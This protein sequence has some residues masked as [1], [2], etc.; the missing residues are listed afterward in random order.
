LLLPA[1]QKVREAAARA[2]C[3]NNLKQMSLAVANCSDTHQGLMPPGD[4]LYPNP[5]P[6]ANNSYASVLF[7]ILP[8]M[9]Q[10]NSYNLTLQ[11]SD[12]HGNNVGAGGANLP[13]YSPFWNYLV[14]NIKTYVCPTDPSNTPNGWTQS[15]LCSYTYN[16]QAFP[17]YWNGYH[18]F[19]ASITDGTS[20]SIFFTEG[21]AYCNGWWFDW[22][23]SIS[24]QSWPQPTGPAALFVPFK[25]PSSCPWGGSQQYA[26]AASAHTGGINVGMGDGSI[27][28]V[29]QGI[30]GNT[31]WFA[32]TVNGSDI[33]GPD[34]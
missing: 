32:L 4:G 30:S 10:S 22:G 25:S 14:A 9:E 19:P 6:S 17:I 16:A 33:L 28:F 20:L 2:Q 13:T 1:V 21:S 34:W 24:D 26:V 7:H 8:Y 5:N 15:G 11:P 29:P 23:P 27:R 31:W 12:P 18:K 3:Q